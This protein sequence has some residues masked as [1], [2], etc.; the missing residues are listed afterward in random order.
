MYKYD[1]CNGQLSIVM[2]KLV[3]Y[4]TITASVKTLLV[5]QPLSVKRITV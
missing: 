3:V 4:K 2:S 1:A 5:V